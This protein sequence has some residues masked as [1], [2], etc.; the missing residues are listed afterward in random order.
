[1]SLHWQVDYPY[2][3]TKEVAK[4]FFKKTILK[5]LWSQKLQR[6]PWTLTCY[7][8]IDFT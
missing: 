7:L 1:M 5:E 2:W 6:S 3:T 4:L 8:L